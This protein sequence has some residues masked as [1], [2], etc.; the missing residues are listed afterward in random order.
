MRPLPS[1]TTPRG[2]VAAAVAVAALAGC[3]TGVGNASSDE[4]ELANIAPAYIVPKSTPKQLV[5]TFE[6]VC[7]AGTLEDARLALRALDYAMA[8][9][10]KSGEGVESYFSDNRRPAVGLQAAA[11]G[12]NCVMTVRARTGQAN[13]VDDYVAATFPT[14]KAQTRDAFERFWLAPGTRGGILFTQ[15]MG[16]PARPE[17]YSFGVMRPAASKAAGEGRT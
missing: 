16:R 13:A 8:R 12:F 1:P 2:R 15:R 10:S 11:G 7:M 5:G 14:R 9:A 6:Q 4:I 3:S 17:T